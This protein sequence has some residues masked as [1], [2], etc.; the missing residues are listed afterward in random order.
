MP[1]IVHVRLET[2]VDNTKYTYTKDDI[3]TNYHMST[4][5]SEIKKYQKMWQY[6]VTGDF[7]VSLSALSDNLIINIKK[8][9]KALYLYKRLC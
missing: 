4:N 9:F 8:R 5:L 2:D 7:I 6:T 1:G 3:C